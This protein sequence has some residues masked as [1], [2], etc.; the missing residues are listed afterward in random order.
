MTLPKLTCSVCE[1]DIRESVLD[2]GVYHSFNYCCSPECG[3]WMAGYACDRN[4]SNQKTVLWRK[5]RDSIVEELDKR[6]R[7][8]QTCNHEWMLGQGVVVSFNESFESEEFDLMRCRHCPAAKHG[9]KRESA[10]R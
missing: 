9:A 5:N 7:Q 8:M 6:D 1:G 2:P 3:Q 4:E 10:G